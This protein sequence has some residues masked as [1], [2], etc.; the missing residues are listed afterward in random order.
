MTEDIKIRQ[1]VLVPVLIRRIGTFH[2]THHFLPTFQ[3]TGSNRHGKLLGRPLPSFETVQ[4]LPNPG[5]YLFL[6]PIPISDTT[7]KTKGL[8]RTAVSTK[9][10]CMRLHEAESMPSLVH[11]GL[12]PR[13]HRHPKAFSR[14]D[15]NQTLQQAIVSNTMLIPW[16]FEVSSETRVAPLVLMPRYSEATRN[17]QRSITSISTSLFCSGITVLLHR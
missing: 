3:P 14:F 9:Q 2:V 13:Y 11:T 5:F 1:H 12:T 15:G 17:R 7:E 8:F 10:P 4:T 16:A 6:H